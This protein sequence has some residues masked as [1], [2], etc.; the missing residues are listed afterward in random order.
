MRIELDE[1]YVLKSDASCF[2]V[3]V[4]RIDKKGEPFDDPKFYYSD[5][6]Q[7]IEGFARR[8]LLASKARTLNG[9]QADLAKIHA[10]VAA[11]REAI[12]FTVVKG[13]AKQEGDVK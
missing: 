12:Y 10:E 5:F 7:A 1:K 13:Q 8:K 4:K 3:C 9:L 6:H 2:F 11:I